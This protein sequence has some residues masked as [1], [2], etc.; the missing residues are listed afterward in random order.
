MFYIEDLVFDILI[1]E[2][3]LN[4]LKRN[5]VT[6]VF[7]IENDNYILKENITEI[8]K[9]KVLDAAFGFISNEVG[10]YSL[11]NEELMQSFNTISSG[12]YYTDKLAKSLVEKGNIKRANEILK[13]KIKEIYDFKLKLREEDTKRIK[14]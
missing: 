11:D 14:M 3:L 8:E 2:I 4:Y 9:Y 7:N 5:N 6:D 10:Q 1:P 13:N 12:I